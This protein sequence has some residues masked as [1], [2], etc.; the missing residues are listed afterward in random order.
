MDYQLDAS[1]NAPIDRTSS[2]KLATGHESSVDSMSRTLAVQSPGQESTGVQDIQPVVED[3]GHAGSRLQ[4]IDLDDVSNANGST[5]DIISG[6]I[7]SPAKRTGASPS[8]SQPWGSFFSFSYLSPPQASYDEGVSSSPEPNSPSKDKRHA[9][10]GKGKRKKD[11][12]KEEAIEDEAKH[13]V[14]EEHT[15]SSEEVA[16]KFKD[17]NISPNKPS[18]SKGLSTA[19]AKELLEQNG[20]NRL[21]P[22]K[23][24]SMCTLYWRQYNNLFNILLLIAALLCLITFAIDTDLQDNLYVAIV[25]FVIIFLQTFLSFLQERKTARL[26]DAFTAFIPTKSNVIRDGKEA[27]IATSDLVVGD[28][29]LISEGDKIPADLRLLEVSDLKVEQAALTGESEPVSRSEEAEPTDT[30]VTE[31]SCIAFNGTLVTQGSG[32]GVVV[33]TGDETFIGRIAGLTSR[34]ETGLTTLEREVNLFVRF[35]AYLAIAMAT[36]F[37]AIGLGRK[38]GDDVLSTFVSGFIVIIVANVPQGLPATV[39]SLL[40]IATKRLASRNIF[41]KKLNY[42][43]TLGAATV[44]CSDKTGTLTKNEMTVTELWL[45]RDFFWQEFSELLDRKRSKSTANQG[46]DANV[47]NTFDMF[48]LV[49]SVC[50]KA[51]IERAEDSASNNQPMLGSHPLSHDSSS[52]Y[53]SASD[54][55]YQRSGSHAS[56]GQS[57]HASNAAGHHSRTEF[58]GQEDQ[59]F[60]SPSEVALL[61]FCNGLRSI[62]R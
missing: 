26:Q 14:I 42:V 55:R 57:R 47:P 48:H 45:D 9:S 60:G 22:P 50:N 17:S 28:I 1:D 61:R 53:P 44:I 25:L 18:G 36:V 21:T 40:T 5:A 7:S 51:F 30:I 56:G 29:V 39:T 35:I 34:T 52:H 41:V 43:E 8:P 23:R 37:F 24:V 46:S 13:S 2:Y 19:R 4:P 32:V 62:Q 12:D 33:A 11:E 49:S 10:K 16:N 38:E 27:N 31:A 59:Y 6:Q 15:M 3:D 20:P 58:G 54:P